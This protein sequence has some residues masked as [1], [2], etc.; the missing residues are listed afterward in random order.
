[1]ESERVVALD[2]AEGRHVEHLSAL[3]RLAVGER[4]P[5]RMRQQVV[6]SL[7]ER[8]ADLAQYGTNRAFAVVTDPE[9]H[10]IENVSQH[11]RKCIKH[12]L[13][14]GGD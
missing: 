13:A 11:T 12:D 9:A 3:E 4:P 10:R 1:M 6:V 14:L 7:T 2:L 8:I 5:V